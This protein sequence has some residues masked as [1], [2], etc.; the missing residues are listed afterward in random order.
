MSDLNQ[1]DI[2][3]VLGSKMVPTN[4]ARYGNF[5]LLQSTVDAIQAREDSEQP[6]R[7]TAGWGYEHDRLVVQAFEDTRNGAS[8]DALLWDRVLLDTFVAR[9]RELGLDAES[10]VLNRRLINV[11]KNKN[12]FEK[13]GIV[14]SPTTR[15]EQKPS[16]VPRHAA[17]V[18][19]ALVRLRYRFGLSID[20]ILM[21]PQTSDTYEE[22]VLNWAPELSREDIRRAAL[23][24]RKTRFI[25][26][27][28][29][30]QIRAL[31]LSLVQNEFSVPTPLSQIRLAEVPAVPGLL[32]VDE[33]DRHLYVV[34][35]DN[36]RPLVS[37]FACGTA[38]EIVKNDFWIP[39]PDEITL[40]YVAGTKIGGVSL[41]KWEHRLISEHS[42]VFN[43]PMTKFAA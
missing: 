39:N 21:D 23:Y 18:E 10:R 13:R 27:R 15:K 40:R 8:T 33:P 31:D 19:F 7:D 38:F 28:E 29:A 41:R 43:W 1:Y 25:Q 36:L 26:K 2:S 30:D 34:H 24:V 14:I 3:R 20:D 4:P 11:R 16:I 22:I 6:K 37:R 32:E 42:P 9:C 12:R 35:I 5:G 17:V